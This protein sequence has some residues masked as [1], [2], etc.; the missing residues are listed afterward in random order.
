ML[1]SLVIAHAFMSP[2]AVATQTQKALSYWFCEHVYQPVALTCSASVIRLTMRRDTKTTELLRRP[3]NEPCAPGFPVCTRQVVCGT[4][5][6]P[7]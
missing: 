2:Y 7:D 3:Q 6:T 4:P 1:H 5:T